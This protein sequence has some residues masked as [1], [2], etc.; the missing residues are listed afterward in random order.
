MYSQFGNTTK[1]QIHEWKIHPLNSVL[2]QKA[3]LFS[4]HS[5]CLHICNVFTLGFSMLLQMWIVESM[6]LFQ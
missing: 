6:N 2:L 3:L 1:E 5:S 4:V